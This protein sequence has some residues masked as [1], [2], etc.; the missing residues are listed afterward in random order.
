M[1]IRKLT[2][3][4]LMTGIVLSAACQKKDDKNVNGIYADELKDPAKIFSNRPTAIGKFVALFKLQTPSLFEALKTDQLKKTV[5]P[6]LL[7]EI[8]A[9]QKAFINAGCPGHDEV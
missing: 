7:A 1:L 9:E 3:L 5:D 4:L 8:E 6:E 2:S